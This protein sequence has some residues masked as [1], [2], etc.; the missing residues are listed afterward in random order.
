ML[1]GILT[2]SSSS[3]LARLTICP[4][5][6]SSRETSDEAPK[7]VPMFPLLNLLADCSCMDFKWSCLAFSIAILRFV[8]SPSSVSSII[9][10][11]LFFIFRFL[12]GPLFSGPESSVLL[13]SGSEDSTPP[14]A[15]SHSEI[16]C[17]S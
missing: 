7:E 14:R 17:S 12:T 13:L 16:K 2:S 10:L 1:L 6:A 3:S 9:L 11:I 8:S 5:P 4:S 15:L